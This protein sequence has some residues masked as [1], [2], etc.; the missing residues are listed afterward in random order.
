[1]VQMN[2][3]WSVR[4]SLIA[5]PHL[6]G[7]NIASNTEIGRI[8]VIQ[9]KKMFLGII[10]PKKNICTDVSYLIRNLILYWRKR[11]LITEEV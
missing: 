2:V 3:T 10:L 1:V 7:N 8:C 5:L 6:V 11:L 9:V 4:R